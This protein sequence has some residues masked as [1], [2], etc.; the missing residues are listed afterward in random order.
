M[1]GFGASVARDMADIFVSDDNCVVTR[2]N[3]ISVTAAD[4]GTLDCGRWVKGKP[5][6]VAASLLRIRPLR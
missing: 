3:L 2:V 1:A 6:P 4:V 5:Q